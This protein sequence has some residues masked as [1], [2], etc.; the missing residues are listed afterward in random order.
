[1]RSSIM[2]ADRRKWRNA[3]ALADARTLGRG[4]G[5]SD[6]VYRDAPRN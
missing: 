4:N 6:I 5:G 3:L 1:M 2:A